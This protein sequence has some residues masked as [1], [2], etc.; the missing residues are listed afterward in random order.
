MSENNP[1]ILIKKNNSI[2]LIYSNKDLDYYDVDSS[3]GIIDNDDR[4]RNESALGFQYM[5]KYS[6][7]TAVFIN[8]VHDQRE[9]TTSPDNN[10]DFRNSKGWKSSAGL[11]Y[12]SDTVVSKIYIQNMDREYESVSFDDVDKSNLG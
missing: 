8:S 10:G 4:D 11:K 2:K 12:A 7:N 6:T 1:T 5:Y 9:Y 3:S